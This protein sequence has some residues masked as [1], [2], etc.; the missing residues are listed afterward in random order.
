[1]TAESTTSPLSRLPFDVSS[2]VPLWLDGKEKLS[3]GGTFDVTSPLNHQLRYTAAAC[4]HEDVDAAVA[5]AKRAFTSWRRST[6]N[7]R[8]DVFLRASD[9]FERRWPEYKNFSHQETGSSDMTH[10]VDFQLAYQ[11]MRN[12][13]GLVQTVQGQ[14][15]SLA[16]P[17]QS[18]MVLREPYGPC[19]AI[20][21][22][23]MPFILGLR[24]IL[25]P[26]ATGNTVVLKGSELSP[27][28]FWSLASVLHEAGLPA[29]VL[30]TVY[31]R[32]ADAAAIT[33]A[34]IAHPD[35]QKVNF[36]GSTHV[37]RVIASMCG[38][39]LKPCVL[40]LGGKA[41]M[42]VCDDADVAKA[43]Q[44]AAVGAFFHSGQ[45]CM[46]T[47]RLIVQK[48]IAAAF[49]AALQEA[50][51]AMFGQEAL[52]LVGHAAVQRNHQLMDEAVGKGAKVLMG[53]L[54]ESGRP[55]GATRMQPVVL[56]STPTNAGVYHRESFGP[57]VSM[58]EVASDA[59]A[60]AMANDT[61][62]GL[63]AAVFTQ[64]LAR[65]F[66][67]AGAIESGA[68]HVNSMTIHDESVLPHGGVKSSGFGRFNGREGLEEW[69][70]T[71]TVTWMHE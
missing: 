13:A 15:P 18:A 47:E 34:L 31:A 67:M 19:L 9:V 26:L 20:A 41:P 55:E 23:N 11:T 69:V 4:N 62:Y 60:I 43:A 27:G 6:P 7:E 35:I 44:A 48:P 16:S 32:T 28:V 66:R 56:E 24:A 49:K 8:R 65:G 29:G 36:T 2:T 3:A 50:V 37:G 39:H 5:S 71:K 68:V 21:P 17:G 70:R 22:W 33:S 64:D 30:N 61:E 54:D 25:Y 63:T 10:A 51:S 45:V 57:T 14:V 59:E 46:A 42:I 58:Y 53:S 12:V 38:Q 1:M 52:V 40:E